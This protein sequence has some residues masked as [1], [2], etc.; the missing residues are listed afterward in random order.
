[1][2]C[3]TGEGEVYRISYIEFLKKVQAVKESWKMVVANFMN[4]ELYIKQRVGLRT[5]DED[6]LKSDY[7]SLLFDKP[8]RQGGT[9]T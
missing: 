5:E 6:P 4:K 3:Q 8:A 1:V 9:Q 2:K 7:A